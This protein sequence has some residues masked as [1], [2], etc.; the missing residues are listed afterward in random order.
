VGGACDCVVPA[1]GSTQNFKLDGKDYPNLGP[2]A[3]SG[4]TTSTRRVS[5]RALELTSKIDGNVRFTQQMEVSPDLN[6][7]T[8]TRLTTG[9]TEPAIQVF[10]RQ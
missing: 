6:T 10:E 2:N 4:S 8:F 1:Q 7:L 9:Q 3:A 5:E